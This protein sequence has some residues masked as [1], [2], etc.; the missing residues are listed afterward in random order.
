MLGVDRLSMEGGNV[1]L[2]HITTNKG[3]FI[4]LGDW[5]IGAHGSLY[6]YALP[7]VFSKFPE[8]YA[9]LV[10]DFVD[11]ATKNS[12]GDVYGARLTPDEQIEVLTEIFK[13]YKERILGVV[14][15]NHDYRIQKEVGY[16]PIGHLCNLFGIAYSRTYMICD[17]S[18][19]VPN[20]GSRNMA[21]LTI[22]LHHGVSGGRSKTASV[23]QGE[24]FER[25]VTAGVDVYVTGHTHRPVA[26]PFSHRIYDKQNKKLKYE[27]GYLITVPSML[28]EEEYANRK[29]LEP[30]SYKIPVLDV[31]FNNGLRN[32]EVRMTDMPEISKY[33]ERI[34]NS[35]SK[36]KKSVV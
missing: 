30:T 22:A 7:K 10:G 3:Q 1:S 12:V 26:V 13:T 31:Q 19:S 15:G 25:F 20:W 9:F 5:H 28:F 23:R 6:E 36:S 17:L 29:M 24:F 4:F 34:S 21:S 8:A 27:E 35:N 18:F 2:H 32:L 11:L 16:D 33:M 14:Q